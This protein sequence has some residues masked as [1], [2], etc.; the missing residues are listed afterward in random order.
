[1]LKFWTICENI[2]YAPKPLEIIFLEIK[3]KT[4]ERRSG[5]SVNRFFGSSKRINT[6]ASLIVTEVQNKPNNIL[7][8]TSILLT[9]TIRKATHEY[10][11][12]NILRTMDKSTNMNVDI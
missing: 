8:I 6:I 11:L 1:M 7:S 3:F 9:L 10:E 2:L 5:E 4:I 12:N